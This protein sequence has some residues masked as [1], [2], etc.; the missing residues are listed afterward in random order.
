MLRRLDE[1]RNYTLTATDGEIG[2]CADFL[3]DDVDW[4]VRYMVADTRKWLPGRKVLVSPHTLQQPDT[5]TKHFPITLS[6]EELKNAPGLEEHEPVSRQYEEAYHRHFGYAFYWVG[7]DIWGTYP[8]ARGALHPVED[9][10]PERVEIKDS[11]L[12]SVEEVTG[13]EAYAS[14]GE[15]IGKVHDFLAEEGVWAIRWLVIEAGSWLSKRKLYLASSWTRQ[16]DWA[17]RSVL[18]DLSKASIESSPEI[19]PDIP[20][21]VTHEKILNAHYDSSRN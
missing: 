2:R 18:L 11:H 20:F 17:N 5:R 3:F 14:E 15:S 8:D 1:L 16:V 9:F 12:R 21:E 13:Y 4:A 10:D 6:R 7:T 19:D